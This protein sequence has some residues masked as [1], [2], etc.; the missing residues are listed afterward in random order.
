MAHLRAEAIASTFVFALGCTIGEGTHGDVATFGAS[1]SVGSSTV[2]TIGESSGDT[3]SSD[4]GDASSS[5]GEST[6]APATTDPAESSSE[7]GDESSSSTGAPP[8][9][10]CVGLDEATCGVTMG[11]AWPL[12]QNPFGG[13]GPGPCGWDPMVCPSHDQATC[14]SSPACVWTAGEVG[15]ACYGVQCDLLDQAT[16]PTIAGCFWFMDG[17][18][19]FCFGLG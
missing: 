8:P 14:M 7:G 18:A 1:A 11:C 2:T 10:D 15:D 13:M 12:N 16:C 6:G 4:G 5:D 19:G 9:V 17:G 3:S